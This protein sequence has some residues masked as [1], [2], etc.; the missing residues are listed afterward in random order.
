M[1]R[2]RHSPSPNASDDLR[3]TPGVPRG[4]GKLSN[5]ES[6]GA[7]PP[8]FINLLQQLQYLLIT[9][10]A[11]VHMASFLIRLNILYNFLRVPVPANQGSRRLEIFSLALRLMRPVRRHASS[12]ERR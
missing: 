7:D 6:D 8:S 5:E 12:C 11:T 3:P 9:I 4:A 10:E 1:P 2:V